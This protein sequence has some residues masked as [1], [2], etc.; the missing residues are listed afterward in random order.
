MQI[1]RGSTRRNRLIGAGLIALLLIAMALDT[2]VLTPTA[3]ADIGPKQFDPAATANDL[4]TKAQTVLPAQA[5]PLSEVLPAVDVDIK[6]AAAKYKA[7]SPAG[8]SYVFFVSATATVTGDTTADDLWLKINGLPATATVLVPTTTAVN[9]TVLRDAMGFT[10][11]DAPD[12][13]G[14]QLVGDELKKLIQS[15]VVAG[16][17]DPTKLKGKKITL[18]GVLSVTASPGS[19]TVPAAKPANVQPVKIEVAG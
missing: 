8:G 19:N 5:K 1:P 16:V 9:G 13:T 17:G 10:F 11:Q 15:K 18:V 2:K 3:L 4:F 6:G 7:V 12:Q 14:Y